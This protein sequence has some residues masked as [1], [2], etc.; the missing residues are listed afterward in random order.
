M[1]PFALL[2]AACGGA[3]VPLGPALPFDETGAV[4][5]LQL[6]L[7]E[8]RLTLAP[9]NLPEG[10]AFTDRF[11]LGPVEAVPTVVGDRAA[12]IYD[13]PFPTRPS[14]ERFAPPGM[15][16][17]VEGDEVPYDISP[18]APG[19]RGWRLKDGQLHVVFPT[20][21]GP[22]SATLLHPALVRQ[23]ARLEFERS[24]L[25]EPEFTLYSHTAFQQTRPGL[26]LPAPSA[27]E[28][29]VVLPEGAR[30]RAVPALVPPPLEVGASD[31]AEVAL[32]VIA[33]GAA[34]EVDRRRVSVEGVVPGWWQAET[35]PLPSW[36]VDLSRWGGRA[37]TLRLES[38]VLGTRDYD[39]VFVGAPVV[40]GTPTA[41]VRRVV[42]VGLDTTRQDHFG[43]HGHPLETTPELDAVAARS[44]VFDR[45]WAPAPRTRPS[46]RSSTTGRGALEAVGATNIG[47]VFR[48]R[49]FAT[50]GFA[51]NVHLSPRFGFHDGFDEWHLDPVAK[52]GDQVDHALRWLEE[53]QERDA[54]LFLHLMDPHLFYNAPEPFRERFVVE[55]APAIPE[56]FTRWQVYSWADQGRLTPGARAYIEALYD[57][58]LAYT[59]HELKRLFEGL[60]ALGGNDLVVVH[61][62]H[63]EEFWDHGGFE[64]NHTLYEELVHAALWVR[65]PGGIEGGLRIDE[66]AILADIAPTL[67]DY[68]GFADTPP[69]DGR[70]LRPLIEG[71]DAGGWDR[72]IPIGHLMYD[73]EQWGVVY[74]G[75]KYVLGTATGAEHLWDLTADPEEQHDLSAERDLAPFRAALALAH[76]M[77][78]GPG[79][80][81][82]VTFTGSSPISW[83][84]PEAC[85][86]AGVMDPEAA[87]RTRANL[88]WGEEPRVRPE[89]VATVTVSA[90]RRTLTIE[91]EPHGEGVI[92][93]MFDRE[94]P[95][96]GQIRRDEETTV[97]ATTPDGGSWAQVGGATFHVR[98]G[99]VLDPPPGEAARMATAE[100][101]SEADLELLRAL[102]YLHDP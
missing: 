99:T 91:P 3:P 48:E 9:S 100:D 6:D 13:L 8:A 7:L 81:A 22:L 60:A 53:N 29:D 38:R 51:A 21:R 80:R 65:P 52:A 1:V 33:N 30:F 62:D 95:P 74:Q 73:V 102:G 12:Y 76:R 2:L 50:A 19:H 94:I 97:L 4:P 23:L 82:Q 24:G 90:D 45:A 66:P 28:W 41:P 101:A 10:T 15:Q 42:V 37:V 92:W 55:P 70:S 18:H 68:V 86:D 93:V 78:V 43:V 20:D 77:P 57:G 96:G 64:H 47:E 83:Q 26:L 79:W 46:F 75:H 61:T 16:V 69:S 49:G 34:I 63:G 56:L 98:P 39:Y 35:E 67:Y 32:S 11:E 44:A 40:W 5:P 85:R 71:R 72:P 25:T 17:L 31:G 54:Y 27:A 36:E 89:E 14:Q 87:R 84:L 88:A 58:E 59:S